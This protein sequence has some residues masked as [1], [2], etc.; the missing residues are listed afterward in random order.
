MPEKLLKWT[1]LSPSELTAETTPWFDKVPERLMKHSRLSPDEFADLSNNFS[2]K[3]NWD[4]ATDAKWLLH[5]AATLGH[6]ATVVMLI[7]RWGKN[8][9][10]DA[11][12]ALDM[13]NA[14]HI[15]CYWGN[16]QIVRRFLDF[17][18]NID[19]VDS[20]NQTSLHKTATSGQRKVTS[21]LLDFGATIDLKDDEGMT[22]LDCA[23]QNDRAAIVR[24]FMKQKGAF[25]ASSRSIVEVHFDSPDQ[26]ENPSTD[27]R[28][29]LNATIVD[30]VI[31]TR[32]A[33][34]E[35]EEHRVRETAVE[36]LIWGSGRE[37]IEDGDLTSNF[38]W[39]HLPANN[40][41]VAF[42]LAR[43]HSILADSGCS[44]WYGLR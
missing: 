37:P 19:S 43:F 27:L 10:I 6:E 24:L 14:M 7:E 12:E 30:F 23:L 34:Q 15:A 5:E 1:G 25:V 22:P 32:S 36:D 21:M 35:V 9:E 41:S 3:I 40:V 38:Q 4:R 18:V 26:K 17:G 16:E 42:S 13:P 44:R 29:G 39:I 28:I 2:V 31:D 11:K 8:D 33:G 20:K